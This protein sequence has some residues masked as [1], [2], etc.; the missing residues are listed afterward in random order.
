MEHAPAP[1]SSKE[2]AASAASRKKLLARYQKVK[3]L[4]SQGMSILAICRALGMSRGP[5]K[6]YVHADSFPERRHPPQ[7][8]MLDPFKPYLAKRWGG[9][10]R[11]DAAMEGHKGA[12]LSG[13][14]GACSA[15]GEAKKMG[16]S[17]HYAGQVRGLDA[18]EEFEEL[19][20]LAAEG[21]S[22]IVFPEAS[23][24]DGGRPRGSLLRRTICSPVGHRGLP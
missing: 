12:G 6:G 19:E 2:Q 14:P 3:K 16:V 5:V 8:S 10:P 21:V 22:P 15:M 23:V 20:A 11:S 17:A 18:K 7:E 9:L 13:C 24:D 4:H 1:R